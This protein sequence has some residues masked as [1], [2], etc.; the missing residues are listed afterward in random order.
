MAR[1]LAM[2][3][4]TT[5][6]PYYGWVIC[7]RQELKDLPIKSSNDPTSLTLCGSTHNK[8]YMIY[9]SSIDNMSADKYTVPSSSDFNAASQ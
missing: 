6:R 4:V 8:N 2:Q 7:R 1:T 5:I 3:I 9:H